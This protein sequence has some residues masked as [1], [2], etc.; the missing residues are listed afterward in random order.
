MKKDVV[1]LGIGNPLMTDEGVGGF[2]IERL[3]TRSQNFPSVEF[4]DAGTAGMNILHLIAGRVKAVIIDCAYMGAE[5]GTIKRFTPGDVESVKK[6]AHYSLHEADLLA[7]IEMAKKLG[8]CPEEIVI[9][10][11]EPE[12]VAAGME[13]SAT[14]SAGIEDYI[15]NISKELA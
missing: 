10:G 12:I 5:P 6:L 1:V 11:I 15:L 3:L 8:Q 4:I 9:F 7:I 14:I 2:L 13:L